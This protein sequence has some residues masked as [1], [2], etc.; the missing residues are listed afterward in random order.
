MPAAFCYHACGLSIVSDAPIAGLRVIPAAGRWDLTV[1]MHGDM[2]PIHAQ[3]ES[4]S[5]WYVSPEREE[6]GAPLLTIWTGPDGYLLRYSEGAAYLVD[7]RG[8]RVQVRWASPLTEADA[9]TYPGPR[10]RRATSGVRTTFM[11][12]EPRTPTKQPYVAPKLATYGDITTLT[13][14]TAQAKQKADGGGR[15]KTRTA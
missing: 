10:K 6:S 4:A 3:P 9:A 8:S 2:G 14:G 7:E 5:I 1:S 11:S 15:L 12:D 13:Q